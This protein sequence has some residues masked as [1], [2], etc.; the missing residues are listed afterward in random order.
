MNVIRRTVSLGLALLMV[1]AA[2]CNFGKKPEQNPPTVNPPVQ[3]ATA[4]FFSDWQAQHLIPEERMV[5]DGDAGLRATEVVK[6]L[7]SG[8]ADPYLHRTVPPEVRLLEPVKV[9]GGIARVNLSQ[10]LLDLRGAAAVNAALGS[11]RLSLTEIKGIAKVNVLVEGKEGAALDEG[12]VLEPMPRPFY[13]DRPVLLDANRIRYLQERVAQGKDP[14]RT[15]LTRVLQWEG[16][17]FGFTLEQLQAA[18]ISP[19]NGKAEA[20]IPY[21][22]TVYFIGLQQNPEA[23]ENRVWSIASITSHK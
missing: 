8:P 21:Q 23:A 22:G 13:G 12:I 17:M 1:A 7:L 5:S 10:E 3:T 11:L 2:G 16:R 18:Q 19:E 15:D 20:Q 9:E 6:E 4:V 14:W